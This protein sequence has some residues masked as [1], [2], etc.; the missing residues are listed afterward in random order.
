[1]ADDET[2]FIRGEEARRLLLPGQ[3]IIENPGVI[4]RDAPRPT[5][6]G[7]PGP[8]PTVENTPTSEGTTPRQ[9]R[10]ASQEDAE[11]Q[12]RRNSPEAGGQGRSPDAR[13]PADEADTGSGAAYT[14][15]RSD[16]RREQS[17]P[18][19]EREAAPA[20]PGAPHYFVEQE[21]QAFY[22]DAIVYIEGEDVSDY[23]LGTI[24]VVYGLGSSPNKCDLRLDNAGHKF[25]LTPENLQ[26]ELFRSVKTTRGLGRD[27]DYSESAKQNMFS[28]K[29]NPGYNPVDPLSGGRRFPLH[30]WSTI[31]HKNDSVRVF[32][33]NPASERDEWLPAFT[34]YVINKPVN[35]NYI[36]GENTISVTCSDIRY[37]MQKMRVNQNSVLAVLPGQQ[38]TQAAD[39]TDTQP[40]TGLKVFSPQSN[41]QFSR[42]F[43]QDLTVSSMYDNPWSTLRFRDLVA[44]LTFL[45]NVQGLMNREGRNVESRIDATRRQTLR[46]LS[47][48]ISPLHQR[49]QA[50][51][52]LTPTERAKYNQL[53]SEI[54]LA[55]SSVGPV[56]SG[57]VATPGDITTPSSRSETQEAASAIDPSTTPE[58]PPGTGSNGGAGGGAGAPSTDARTSPAQ[59][60]GAGRIGRMRPGVFP[61]FRGTV[62]GES[63][64]RY[65]RE[66]SIYPETG[67]S[68]FEIN[69]FWKNWYN[70]CLF[71]SPL[72]KN[73]QKTQ[74]APRGAG[75][76]RRR[77]IEITV[78]DGPLDHGVEHRRYW[79]E[80]E[81]HA[82]GS[83]T[84][85][86]GLWQTD[87]QAVHMILPARNAPTS[88][89]LFEIGVLSQSNVQQNLNWATRLSIL[90]DAVDAVDYRFWVSG[91]GDL[92]FE[93]AQYDFDPRDYGEYEGVL[94]L[95]H[96]LISES[97]DEEGG[98]VVTAVV[99]NGSYVGRG[100]VPEGQDLSSFAPRVV[101]VWSPSL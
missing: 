25:T 68:S 89:L 40:F 85:R 41:Q 100:D 34:G 49:V 65:A 72:R 98:E 88:D 47:R 77:G 14:S 13:F 1:M 15:E 99:A 11:A 31:F 87:A 71:G 2:R 78:S 101:G 74:F 27:F 60:H 35:E 56:T 26:E 5:D 81:V 42:S 86:E 45:N 64:P 83:E 97:F 80:S 33:H 84:R 61:W 96:H 28:R 92:I 6:D 53:K 23:L 51:R 62:S 44:A 73:I 22:H 3:T 57:G 30:H 32:I 4:D 94:T 76:G 9:V 43:F 19:A 16:A 90:N 10:D 29:K 95:D 58:D 66:G 93:F 46:N 8:S 21:H 82:A 7:I 55:E 39:P 24:S 59:P 91:S 54:N 70:L 36:T 17:D 50:G 37:N 67:A 52:T 75:G 18:T 48:E 79:T 38:G 69:S 20:R 12:L 63:V